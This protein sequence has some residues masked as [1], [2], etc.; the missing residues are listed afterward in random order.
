MIIRF[1]NEI[2]GQYVPS[3]RMK[4]HSNF[5]DS[6]LA[7]GRKKIKEKAIKTAA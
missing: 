1:L 5:F 4:G 2:T 7:A 6:R 3:K